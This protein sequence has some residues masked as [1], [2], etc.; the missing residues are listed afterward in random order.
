MS[1]RFIVFSI[2][3]IFLIAGCGNNG[4]EGQS[5]IKKDSTFVKYY[6]NGTKKVVGELQNGKHH[7]E[8]RRYYKDGALKSVGTVKNGDKTGLW[9]FYDKSNDLNKVVHYN[10]DTVLVKL[11]KSDFD[12]KKYEIKKGSIN[13]KIPKT[14]KTNLKEGSPKLLL[15]STK[16]NCGSQFR[17]CPSITLTKEAIQN[18]MTFK[19]YLSKSFKV[20][21]GKFDQ[22]KAL[23]EGDL[24]IDNKRAYRLIYVVKERELKI[25]GI[26]TWIKY[27][28]KVYVLTCM[29]EN[30][31]GRDFL[32]FEGL[33]KEITK[34]FEVSQSG[35][36][37]GSNFRY[38]GPT[39][40]RLKLN[41]SGSSS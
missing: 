40:P 21:K 33:F 8:F 13:I 34:S 27:G 41:V 16:K 31:N 18:D 9:K 38:S 14:W 7:G 28:K 1:N 5:Q 30:Q 15:S 20:L 22:F 19:N 35:S 37:L 29:A 17:F 11:D 6:N 24:T 23:A 3:V 2:I 4:D 10:A 39:F 36:Q 12:F 25:G 26:T 32:R